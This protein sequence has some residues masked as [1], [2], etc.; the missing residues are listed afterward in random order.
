VVVVAGLLVD[1][2]PEAFRC[3]AG[4]WLFALWLLPLDLFGVTFVVTVVVAVDLAPFVTIVLLVVLP[5]E[6]ELVFVVCASAGDVINATAAM[7]PRSAFM[8][9][10]PLQRFGQ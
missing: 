1:F 7:D 8:A 4:L 3:F 5:P 9:F 6:D 10:T 2:F